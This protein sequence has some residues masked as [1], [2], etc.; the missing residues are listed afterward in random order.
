MSVSDKLLLLKMSASWKQ[1][2]AGET[3][4][5]DWPTVKLWLNM[6]AFSDYPISNNS[7]ELSLFLIILTTAQKADSKIKNQQY[8]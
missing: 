4:L 3:H 8:K 5:S 2:W 1:P 7:I 6:I